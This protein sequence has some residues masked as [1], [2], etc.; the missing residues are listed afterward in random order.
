MTIRQVSLHRALRAQ[1]SRRT[2]PAG[3][4]ENQT[5]RPS[6]HLQIV[7]PQTSELPPRP[8]TNVLN[9]SIPLFF[10]GQNSRGLWVAREASGQ[11][12]GVFFFKRSAL[13]FTQE[14]SEWSGCATMILDEPLELDISNRGS[15][16][17]ETAD[18]AMRHTP[19][20]T[21]F[22]RMVGAEW[23]KLRADIL[24]VFAGVR[25]NRAAVESELFRGE[26][27]LSSKSD[28]DLPVP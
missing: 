11:S 24:R 23:R 28:D 27:T 17:A 14:D 6:G 3:T 7:R 2:R 12:G 16:L 26:Y 4:A 13:R 15:R 21:D 19:A 10:I 18:L 1:R 5:R 8:D 22:L 25:R 20:L 9:N